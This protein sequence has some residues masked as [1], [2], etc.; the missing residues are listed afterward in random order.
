[1]VLIGVL[2]VAREPWHLLLAVVVVVVASYVCR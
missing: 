1:M 2:G